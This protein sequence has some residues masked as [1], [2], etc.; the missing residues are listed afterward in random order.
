[1]IPFIDQHTVFQVLYLIG[2]VTL[3]RDALKPWQADY[4]ALEEHDIAFS[5]ILCTNGTV[6]CPVLPFSDIFDGSL[7]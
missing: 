4:D 6:L 1:M 5:C 7:L 2:Q 3:R